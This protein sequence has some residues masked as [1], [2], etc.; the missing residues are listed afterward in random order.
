MGE[1]LGG[2][3]YGTIVVLSVVVAGS[4][5]YPHGVGSIAVLVVVTVGVFWLAHVYAHA[6]GEAVA[7]DRHLSLADVRRIARHE[8]SMIEAAVPPVAALLLGAAGIISEKAAVWLAFG[9]GLGV[10]V[11]QGFRFA[12]IERLGRLGTFGVVAANFGLGL[13]LVALKLV[14]SH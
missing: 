5:A 12:R 1:R 11:A 6:V 14:T 10:L 3:I 2:F 8:A 13:L 9:L 4:K 7:H